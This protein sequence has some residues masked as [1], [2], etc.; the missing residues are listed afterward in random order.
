M[1]CRAG[2]GAQVAPAVG[3]ADHLPH[4]LHA[5]GLPR[6]AASRSD[7]MACSRPAANACSPR[8]DESC[9]LNPPL[10]TSMTRVS[11]I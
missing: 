9:P 5:L 3:L 10:Q 1:L 6:S 2:T 7:G 8:A 4:A 11:M